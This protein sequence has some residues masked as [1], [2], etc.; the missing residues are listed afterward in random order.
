[1]L[2]GVAREIVGVVPSALQFP[3]LADVWVPLGDLRKDQGVLIR[4]NHPGFSAIGRLKP[5]VS[6]TQAKADLDTI[7]AEL[8]R[9]YPDS[10]S[11][12]RVQTDLLLESAVGNYRHSLNLLL[13][14]VVC[15]LLIACANVANLQLAHAIARS[16]ELAIRVALGASRWQLMRQMLTESVLLAGFARSRACCSRSGVWTRF[17]R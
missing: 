10:N 3:R 17:W 5:G 2:N 8:E 14:A 7:A 13:A 11:T 4:G 1:M 16:K 12:R 6:M 15:V 9:L